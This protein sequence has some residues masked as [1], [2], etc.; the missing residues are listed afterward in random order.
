MSISQRSSKQPATGWVDFNELRSGVMYE[1]MTS[2]WKPEYGDVV[3]GETLERIYVRKMVSDGMTFLE[4]A[5]PSGERQLIACDTVE[6]IRR[7]VLL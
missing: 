4:V 5:Q 1:F 2:D 3:M 7:L 6:T